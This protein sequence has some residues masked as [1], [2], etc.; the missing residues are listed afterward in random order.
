MTP[1]EKHLWYVYLKKYPVRFLRQKVIDDY[2]ADF[3]CHA[4]KLVIEI[5]GLQHY[6][7]EGKQYDAN[8]TEVIEERGIKVIR[9]SNR[10]IEQNFKEVCETIDKETKER[11]ALAS[12]A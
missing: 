11:T 5:D 1:E 2:I 7:D 3:Y 9:F 10:E 8:R 4:A 12:L 6:T